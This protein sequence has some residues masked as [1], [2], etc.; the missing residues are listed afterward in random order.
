MSL[1]PT[2]IHYPYAW[3]VQTSTVQPGERLTA[4][5]ETVDAFGNNRGTAIEVRL[6]NN[7]PVSIHQCWQVMHVCMHELH[8]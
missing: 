6:F 4:E 2:R 7:S 1:N 3:T 5:L 8:V